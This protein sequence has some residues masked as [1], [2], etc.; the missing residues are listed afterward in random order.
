MD[1]HDSGS[2]SPLPPWDS[3]L[4]VFAR[5]KDEVRV[6]RLGEDLG[7]S[8]SIAARLVSPLSGPARRI[9]LS[10]KDLELFPDERCSTPRRTTKE[11]CSNNTKRNAEDIRI[12]LD[13]LESTLQ[14]KKSEEKGLKMNEF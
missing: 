14:T 11:S 1:G 10:L 4:G 7:R 8:Y 6:F 13:R 3:S 5:Y 9:G 12:L 2:R